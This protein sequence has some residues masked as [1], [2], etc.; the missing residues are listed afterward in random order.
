ML[1]CVAGAGAAKAANDII[2]NVGDTVVELTFVGA[3]DVVVI[4]VSPIG[5]LPGAFDVFIK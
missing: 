4:G 5:S 3:V 1:T 2:R